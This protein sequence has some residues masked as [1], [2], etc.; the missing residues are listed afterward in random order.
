MYIVYNIYCPH[1]TEKFVAKYTHLIFDLVT[2]AVERSALWVL[3]E[4]P[5][6]YSTKTNLGKEL[7]L[8]WFWSG[9][10]G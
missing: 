6:W 8:N 10:S 9:C 7:F 3:K 5:G 4:F 2:S 1:I